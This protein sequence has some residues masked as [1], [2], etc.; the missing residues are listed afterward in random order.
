MLEE[1]VEIAKTSTRGEKQEKVRPKKKKKKAKVI[2]SSS[3]DRSKSKSPSKSPSKSKSGKKKTSL[4]IKL[5][6]S[7][8]DDK[9]PKKS[10]MKTVAST[11]GAG[12]SEPS[13]SGQKRK[14]SK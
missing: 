3:D 8:K 4:K 14:G 2:S 9:L 12:P 10:S 6:I 7:K 1:Q 11:S 5:P 13:G